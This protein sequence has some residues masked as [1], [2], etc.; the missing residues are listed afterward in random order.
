MTQYKSFSSRALVGALL[1]CLAIPLPAVAQGGY[2]VIS[3]L[4]FGSYSDTNGVTQPLMLDLLSPVGT[5]G[6]LPTVVYVFAGAWRQGER[7]DVYS[8][9]A[10]GLCDHGFAVA[11]PDYRLDS[12]TPPYTNCWPVQLHDLKGAVRWLRANA[13]TYNL[14]PNRIGAIGGS[15]GGH[16]SAMLGVAGDVPSVTIGGTTIDLRGGIGGNYE[17]SESVMAVCDTSGPSEMLLW[18]RWPVWV[19][20]DAVSSPVGTLFGAP[21]QTVPEY[22]STAD[23]GLYARRNLPPFLLFHGTVDD[24]VPFN[25]SELFY[26]ALIRAGAKVTFYPVAGGGHGDA[27]HFNVPNVTNVV[28]RFFDRIMKNAT[29]NPL[30]VPSFTATPW[31]SSPLTVTFDGS[32]SQA[33]SGSNLLYAWSYGDNAG[34]GYPGSPTPRTHTYRYSGTYRATLCIVNSNYEVASTSKLVNVKSAVNSGTAPQITLTAPSPGAVALA[35]G[36]VYLRASVTPGSTPASNVDFLVNGQ[37]R[38]TDI[39]TP[40][41]LAIGEL[42][43]GTYTLA[44]RVMDAN[45]LVT[46]SAPVSLSVLDGT[47]VPSFRNV[48][49]TNYF[50]VQFMRIPAA[51]NLSY[52]VDVS[53]DL[54]QDWQP[55]L[56]YCAGADVTSSPYAVQISRSGT[57]IETIVVGDNTLPANADRRF[58]R[59]KVTIP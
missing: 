40:F 29:S 15:S 16:L 57:G 36:A 1:C 23:P 30:P 11:S 35:P 33:G 5:T 20:I 25:Q 48:S 13:A 14:D 26:D 52:A 41:G 45:G 10:V 22:A 3:N 49:G 54:T 38:G 24:M 9:A 53:S 21:V 47:P 12:R 18:D 44:A 6:A 27:A 37:Y 19:G 55:G 32:A 28:Y 42:A 7:Q 2:T 34:E 8:S 31:G 17:F 51:T 43:T 39:M 56:R 46:T 50:T 58:I 59:V 4:V